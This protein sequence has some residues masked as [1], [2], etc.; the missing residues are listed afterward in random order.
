V[1]A[2]SVCPSFILFLA[3]LHLDDA[4]DIF[5]FW[6]EAMVRRVMWKGHFTLVANFRFSERNGQLLKGLPESLRIYGF[7]N[8]TNF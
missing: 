1:E 2:N 7:Y 4:G 8:V 5:L 3:V 6:L